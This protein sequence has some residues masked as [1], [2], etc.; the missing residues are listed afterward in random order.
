[1]PTPSFQGSERH[2]KEL[3]QTAA[4]LLG[5]ALCNLFP[6]TK[7]I[8]TFVSDIGFHIDVVLSQQIDNQSIAY[9]EERVR[10]LASS[11]IPFQKLEMIRSNA[12]HFLQHHKQSILAE[13]L[14]SESSQIIPLL[15][16]DSFVDICT[17][18]TSPPELVKAFKILSFE[19][20]EY[21]ISSKEK[22]KAVRFHGTAFEDTKSLKAFLKRKQ[23][24]GF[25]N[26]LTLIEDLQLC[27]PIQNSGCW[28]WLPK[29]L[30]LRGLLD[31]LS[32][33]IQQS[34]PFSRHSFPP[35]IPKKEGSPVDPLYLNSLIFQKQSFCETDFPVRYHSN[36]S[37]SNPISLSQQ[38][39]L[40]NPLMG[41]MDLFH[42]FCTANQMKQELI[43]SLQFIHKIIKIF[44]FEHQ[45][46]LYSRCPSHCK[47][48]EEW[49]SG[50]EAFKDVLSELQ[51]DYFL[52]KLGETQYGPRVEIK[53][54]DAL[55][56]FWSGPFTLIDVTHPS[57]LHLRYK[58]DENGEEQPIAIIRSLFGL[59][60][61]FVALL[62]EHTSGSLP[63]WLAPEQFRVI[64]LNAS[65]AND[66]A[67]VCN[68]LEGYDFR[69][70]IDRRLTPLSD[71]IHRAERERIPYILILGEREIKSNLIT[72]RSKG[73]VETSV[74]T[75]SFLEQLQQ[76]L[77]HSLQE[78]QIDRALG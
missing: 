8:D 10:Y 35:F 60:E 75:P 77:K 5:C 71:R 48:R 47:N 27:M 28:I 30:Q 20:F 29:G 78:R 67:N 37:V 18:K 24:A 31:A 38:V 54:A 43:S 7:I 4:E 55:G 64:P 1:M 3:R 21:E 25:R 52:D 34:Q 57:S 70:S 14:L 49:K 73:H 16:I 46:I 42:L 44:K 76:D 41:E 56:R 53:I 68:T 58:R 65:C 40:L 74:T 19:P 11:S 39:G 22:L 50:V 12:I 9:I 59:I 17:E 63:L 23:E 6:E 15:M 69:G 62:I 36:H 2:L 13:R 51:I 33:A 32:L 26:H 66:A 45:W 72:V 61:R